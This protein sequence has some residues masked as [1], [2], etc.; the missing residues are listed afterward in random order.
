M[1]KKSLLS[2][3][4]IRRFMGLA[5][6][7]ATTVSNH[8]NEKWGDKKGE[9]KRHDVD[10]VEK[11]AGDVDHHYKA[12]EQ[13]FG[14]NKGDDSETDP[15]HKDYE[16]NEEDEAELEDDAAEDVEDA[17]DDEVDAMDDL[18]DAEADLEAADAG[19]ADVSEDAIQAAVDALADLE[20][21]VQPLADAAGI[22]L[23]DA[24]ADLDA[25]AEVDMGDAEVDMDMG[26]D[27]AAGDLEADAGEDEVA[28]LDDEEVV[29]EVAKR[30]A[31]RILKAR[32]AQKMLD[33]ALGKNTK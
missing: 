29:M 3:A 2:E 18:A 5:G 16:M 4:Q 33:E 22:S 28:A 30:V 6:M 23:D 13:P 21:L 9:Y 19:E 7:E 14:G 26:D 12:Y 8:L 32:K 11:K 17:A 31:R 10:G 27:E 20:A 1:S 15:G 24:A 25:D